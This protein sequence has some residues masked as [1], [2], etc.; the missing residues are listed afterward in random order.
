MEGKLKALKVPELKA[1]LATANVQ[2]PAKVTKPELIAKIISSP[3]ATDAYNAQFNPK[4]PEPAQTDD[5]VRVLCLPYLPLY[6][7]FHF[8]VSWHPLKC[9]LMQKH[10]TN[11]ETDTSCYSLDWDTDLNPSATETDPTGAPVEVESD[12]LTLTETE[13]SASK[14]V[15]FSTIHRQ[16]HAHE[17]RPSQAGA[18]SSSME[19]PADVVDPELEKRR[20]RAERFGIPLVESTKNTKSRP[21]KVAADSRSQAP[22]E[23]FFPLTRFSVC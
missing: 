17:L 16:H 4:E 9:M 6:S 10:A 2:L 21:K 3:A 8:L 11:L 12:K 7:N 13:V 18:D 14:L 1:I 15:C 23:V 19:S 22:T 20:K 5:L